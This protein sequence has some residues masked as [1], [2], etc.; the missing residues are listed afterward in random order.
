MWNLQREGGQ[1]INTMYPDIPPG[2]LLARKTC[3]DVCVDMDELQRADWFWNR[4]PRKLVLSLRKASVI[5]MF[6]FFLWI[7]SMYAREQTLAIAT[8]RG[9]AWVALAATA[10]AIFVDIFRYAQ[11]KWEYGRAI[12]RLLLTATW[13]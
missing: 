12:R 5:L 3:N 7:T 4:R 1:Q 13:D 6:Y 8:I 10:G 9:V 11:W 2:V